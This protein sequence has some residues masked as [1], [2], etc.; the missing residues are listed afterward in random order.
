MLL[1]LTL[2]HLQPEEV[3]KAMCVCVCGLSF[4]ICEMG[5]GTIGTSRQ[6]Q[7]DGGQVGK[8]QPGPEYGQA[9]PCGL[10]PWV[11]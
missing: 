2:P 8:N 3:C 4:P 10:G 9:A 5:T 11:L 6:P 7:G 1:S